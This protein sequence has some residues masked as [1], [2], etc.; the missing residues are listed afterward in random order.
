MI[1]PHALTT[2]VIA[3][4]AVARITS[5][6]VHDTI[7]DLFRHELFLWSPPIDDIENGHWY[8]RVERVP[9][10]KRDH[11]RDSFL[12]ENAPLRDAGFFG[13]LVACTNCTGVWVA[14]AVYAALQLAPT[15]TMPILV[16]AALAQISEATIKASR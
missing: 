10:R 14:G 8:Q 4:L 11:G 16:I 1:D 13:R 5:L 9:F 3:G 7:L 12:R 2:L 6:I 15:Y